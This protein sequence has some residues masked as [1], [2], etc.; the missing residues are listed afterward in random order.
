M[1][2]EKQI[3]RRAEE[4]LKEVGIKK[5]QTVLDCCCGSGIYTTAAAQLVGEKG[6]VYAVDTN[7][8]KL[9]DLKRT[10]KSRKLKI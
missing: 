7:S 2:S 8:K 4:L 1:C 10:F 3:I 9:K 6:L 5:G